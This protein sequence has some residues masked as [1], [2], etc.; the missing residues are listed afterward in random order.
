MIA[1]NEEPDDLE[2]RKAQVLAIGANLVASTIVFLNTTKKEVGSGVVVEIKG[3]MFIATASHVIPRNPD[4]KLSFI[5]QKPFSEEEGKRRILSFGR[6]PPSGI[7][8]IPRPDVGFIEL[9][10]EDVIENL[11]SAAIPLQRIWLGRSG[12][13]DSYCFTVGCPAT[14]LKKVQHRSSRNAQAFVPIEYITAPLAVANWPSVPDAEPTPDTAIDVFTHYSRAAPLYPIIKM[15]IDRSPDPRGMSGG[16]QWQCVPTVANVWTPEN[17]RLFAIQSSWNEK[18]GYLR[19]TQIRHWLDLLC[20]EHPELI[21]AIEQSVE[22]Y[23]FHNP[24]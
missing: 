9:L 23:S 15:D 8:A 6:V 4:G 14:L 5:G 24:S 13:P 1:S 16:G 12:D 17:A 3:R 18:R 2:L 10:P 20:Q 11:R 21:Q 22:G 7:N 19:G